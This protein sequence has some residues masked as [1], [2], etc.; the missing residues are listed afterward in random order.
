M[1]EVEVSIRSVTLNKWNQN[2]KNQWKKKVKFANE[3]SLIN[4]E[5]FVAFRGKHILTTRSDAHL[6]LR[7]EPLLWHTNKFPA[8]PS[9]PKNVYHLATQFDRMLET[10]YKKCH[11]EVV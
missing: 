9:E 1:N 7:S 6:T 10:D 4:V 8:F 3:N 11:D 5:D 2:G